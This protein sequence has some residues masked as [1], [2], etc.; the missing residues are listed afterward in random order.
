M[1]TYLSTSRIF[2]ALILASVW[3]AAG[4][5]RAASPAAT[6]APAPAPQSSYATA[7]EAMTD[8]SAALKADDTQKLFTIFGPE[9]NTVLSVDPVE[10]K[11]EYEAFTKA[12][13]EA[14]KL[15]KVN[16]SKAIIEVGAKA[17][18]LPFPLVKGKDG[19][20]TFDT[21]AGREEI[22]NRR[23]GEN[24]LG[25]ISLL[26]SYVDAQREYASNDW[27][28]SQV[29][30]YAQRLVS[31]PG[32]K[33]G[34]YW[35]TGEDGVISPFGEVVTEARAKGYEKLPYDGYLYRVLTKQGPDAPLGRYDYVTNGKMIGGFGLVAFPAK[36]GNSG[37]MTFIVNQQGIV[38]QKD[39]GPN[40]ES[41]VAAMTEYNPGKG[42]TPSEVEAV[43]SNVG[44]N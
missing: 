43:E 28:G 15:V 40:T 19:R 42:W 38:F 18:P 25:A 12:Y 44:K 6:P 8:L 5:L 14:A 34:L 13:A 17:W 26:L 9:L 1:K 32:K 39:L 21:V 16:D 37:V 41:V 22:V 33:D 3:I 23:V 4:S 24:E 27:D 31:T 10:R 29:L 35:A 2:P 20:W 30:C 36:W 7:E 11:S